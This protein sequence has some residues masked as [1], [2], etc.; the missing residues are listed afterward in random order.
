MSLKPRFWEEVFDE[1]IDVKPS[2]QN[3]V[4]EDFFNEDLVNI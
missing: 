1:I 4:S 2:G 3:E